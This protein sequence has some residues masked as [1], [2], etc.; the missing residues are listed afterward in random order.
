MKRY[1][2]RQEGSSPNLRVVVKCGGPGLRTVYVVGRPT[3]LK[4]LKE[5]ISEAV[6]EAGELVASQ[7]E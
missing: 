7:R 1:V 4:S 6:K 3:P 2:I 5:V